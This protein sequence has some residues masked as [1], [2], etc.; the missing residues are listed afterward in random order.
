MTDDAIRQRCGTTTARPTRRGD[1][2]AGLA[3]PAA[4]LVRR[5]RRRPRRPSSRT[6]FSW[7]PSTTPA[8]RPCAPCSPR[9]STSAASRSSPTTTRPRAAIWTRAATRRSQFVWLAHERQVRLTGPVTRVSREETE[10][11]FA[12]P[13]R[14]SQLGAWASPQSQVIASRA[15][16]ER[17][18]RGRRARFGDGPIPAPPHWGGFRLDPDSVEFWQGRAGPAAR[19]A[20]VPARRTVPGCS[21]AAP[22]DDRRR[23]AAPRPARASRARLR[24]DTAR[25]AHHRPRCARSVSTRRC[26]PAAPAWSA[27][28]ARATV[29]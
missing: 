10:A 14:G 21:K 27:T 4:G 11:Y 1:D 18:G 23:R 13:P 25:P 3:D 29:R 17:A 5:R 28:S 20:A 12:T 8:A 24:G 9:A 19:P 6:P 26:S 16:L 7:P 15:V 22:R 2:R